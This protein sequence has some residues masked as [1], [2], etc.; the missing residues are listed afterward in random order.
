IKSYIFIKRK[1]FSKKLEF[2]K[3]VFMLTF[4][5]TLVI[6]MLAMLAYLVFA[7]I[8]SDQGFL[9]VDFPT[10]L[11]EAFLRDRLPFIATAIILIY[12]IK[13]NKETGLL[14]SSSERL[15]LVMP[16]KKT[17]ILFTL[18]LERWF[19]FFIK[20]MSAGLLVYLATSIQFSLICMY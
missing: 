10:E 8:Q 17:A 19:I 18:A 12:L 15:F 4:D 2:Y 7:F 9:F 14:F 20:S 1:R 5:L 11:V 6:Y 13:S 16:Y 3:R